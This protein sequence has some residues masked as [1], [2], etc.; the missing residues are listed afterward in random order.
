MNGYHINKGDIST[1]TPLQ[2]QAMVA[3]NSNI[4]KW[5]SKNNPIITI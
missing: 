1:M 4:L 3:I 5:K 2:K